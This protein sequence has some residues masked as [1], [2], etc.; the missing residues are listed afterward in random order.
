MEEVKSQHFVPRCYLERFS[1]DNK[2]YAY[3][4]NKRV[5]L[6]KQNIL[7]IAKQ[8]RFY[9]YSDEELNEM[10]K[11]I[12]NIDKQYIEKLFSTNVEP[13]LSD[14][15]QDFS[16]I[17]PN[18]IKSCISSL[19]KNSKIEISYQIIFQL[20][21]TKKCRQLL[22]DIYKLNKEDSAKIHRDLILDIDA[23]IMLKDK[24]IDTQWTIT[25]NETEIKYIT[26][27]NPVVIFDINTGNLFSDK[28]VI[29]VSSELFY[30]VTPDYLINIHLNKLFDFLKES[31]LEFIEEIDNNNVN[32][33]NSLQIK[34]SSA[35]VY[36]YEKTGIE[37]A[38]KKLEKK[39]EPSFI[40]QKT[41]EAR[42]LMLELTK[43]ANSGN[44]DKERFDEIQKKLEYLKGIC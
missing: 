22:S 31:S 36:S 10:K 26:S 11:Y 35:Y 6:E 3:D 13:Q 27:D 38:I 8:N 14:I 30:P 12:S 34:N 24:F 29:G 39:Y 25:I 41:S 1:Q 4:K 23:I 5:L 42:D 28:G 44:I 37:S 15:I 9:D 7:K 18:K 21:R 33:I 19:S 2:I 16:R 32:F 43:M 20:I 17:D 40:I